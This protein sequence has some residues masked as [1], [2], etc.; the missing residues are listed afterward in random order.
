MV[1]IVE[2]AAIVAVCPIAAR[3]LCS[4]DFAVGSLVAEPVGAQFPDL[5]VVR[6]LAV[7]A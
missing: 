1:V 3:G 2:R 5:Q 7:S 4:S 6:L